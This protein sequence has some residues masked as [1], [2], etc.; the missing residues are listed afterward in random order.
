MQ[1]KKLAVSIRFGE[2]EI[3]VGELLAE[4]KRIYFKYYA[5]FIDLPIKKPEAI[6]V[7]FLMNQSASINSFQNN[8]QFL[9]RS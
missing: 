9:L 1:L 3:P 7:F 6:P 4:G 2:E 5:D 8:S